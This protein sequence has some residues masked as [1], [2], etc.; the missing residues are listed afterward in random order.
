MACVVVAALTGCGAE[1]ASGGAWVPAPPSAAPPS[2]TGPERLAKISSAC[3]ILPASAVVKVLGSSSTTKL[4][5]R[6]L[7]VEDVGEAGVGYV[8]DSIRIVVVTL[9]YQED[10][11]LVLFA[12]PKIVPQDKM[13]QVIEE[14]V[15]KV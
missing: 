12:A 11:R 7:P 4:K 14:V 8:S 10:L 1:G 13:V 15:A 6:E 5:A 9:P 3:Q 2:P